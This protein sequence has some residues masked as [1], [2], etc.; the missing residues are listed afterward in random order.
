[1]TEKNSNLL[2][3]LGGVLVGALVGASAA[4]LTAPQS[5]LQTRTMIRNKSVELKDK[6]VVG[7]NETRDRAG[8]ALDDAKGRTGKA[9]V[10]AKSRA[11]VALDDVKNRAGDMMQ[12]MRQKMTSKQETGLELVDPSAT[13]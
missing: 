7:A 10:V 1:M 12:T 13:E 11:G 6:V 5:G 4:L 8:K 3:L 9:L 2:L